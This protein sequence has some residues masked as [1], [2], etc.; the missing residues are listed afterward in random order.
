LLQSMLADTRRQLANPGIVQRDRPVDHLVFRSRPDKV[1]RKPATLGFACSHA[2]NACPSRAGRV[3][4]R[5]GQVPHRVQRSR[6]G[7]PLTRA[8]GSRD[9]SLASC[10]GRNASCLLA[11]AR[12]RV[13]M[14]NESQDVGLG[15]VPG[16][17]DLE[18][19]EL[20]G[21]SIPVN[22]ADTPVKQLS[23]PG[24]LDLA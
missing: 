22:L 23:R 13:R 9:L 19:L 4:G 7:G 24:E 2:V 3:A 12:A 5:N 17:A 6:S 16:S 15:R 20:A 11:T 1:E 21:E 14:L 8:D 10:R 18:T